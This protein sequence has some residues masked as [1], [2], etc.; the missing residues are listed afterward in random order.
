MQHYN[1][2]I[3]QARVLF[4]F[5]A[6]SI[7]EVS[8]TAG[9]IV[10]VLEKPEENWWKIRK[11]KAS[12]LIPSNFL[13]E[14]IENIIEPSNLSSSKK[15]DQGTGGNG[16]SKLN[17]A[18]IQEFE[19][20]VNNNNGS[21]STGEDEFSGSINPFASGSVAMIC[22]PSSLEFSQ[23]ED[24]IA[25][26]P[27]ISNEGVA[28]GENFQF[29]SREMKRLQDSISEMVKT[30]RTYVDDLNVLMHEFF[31]PIS[32]MPNIQCDV[33]FANILSLRDIN[34]AILKDFENMKRSKL[35]VGTI[36]LQHLDSLG[37]YKIY[38]EN[39]YVSSEYLQRLRAENSEINRFLA[40]SASSCRPICVK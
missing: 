33:L 39:M 15:D 14:L 8:C 29:D 20:E 12:G 23:V 19:S 5:E 22:T 4:D 28:L 2:V 35:S 32:L 27:D 37:A 17:E 40:V 25:V 3:S 1:L 11:G 34:F 31:E 18:N 10:D 38:C 21:Y 26:A 24:N 9:D 36:F 16:E 7:D 6:R 30:E 13:E